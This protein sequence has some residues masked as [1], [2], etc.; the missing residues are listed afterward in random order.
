MLQKNLIKNLATFIKSITKRERP[1]IDM[2]YL[3][4]MYQG[5]SSRSLS[6]SRSDYA[7]RGTICP[8]FSV[9]FRV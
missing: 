9:K 1:Y 6:H 5:E 3:H 4:P 8:A 7:S 2:D